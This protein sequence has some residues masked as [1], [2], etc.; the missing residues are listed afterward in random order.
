[1]NKC[2]VCGK[3]VKIS[4]SNICPKCVYD[5]FDLSLGIVQNPEGRLENE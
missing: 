5:E 3:K 2:R 4:I 1:M